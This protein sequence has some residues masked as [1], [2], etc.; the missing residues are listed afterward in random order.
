MGKLC[1][2]LDDVVCLFSTGLYLIHKKQTKLQIILL[3]LECEEYIIEHAFSMDGIL[4]S[5]RKSYS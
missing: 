1:A 4:L 2:K 5:R 3:E